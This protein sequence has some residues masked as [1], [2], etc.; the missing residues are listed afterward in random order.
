MIFKFMISQPYIIKKLVRRIERKTYERNKIFLSV[1]HLY[2]RYPKSAETFRDK[3]FQNEYIDIVVDLLS[4]RNIK[5][6]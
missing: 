6:G 2:S 5:L 3:T 1:Y 4:F